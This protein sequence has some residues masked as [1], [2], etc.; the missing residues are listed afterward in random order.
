MKLFESAI[1]AM[2]DGGVDFIV[3]G[4]LAANLL[5]SR[6][7]TYDID[8][9]FSRSRANLQRLSAALA[10]LH[11]RLR[12]LPPGLPFVWDEKSLRRSKRVQSK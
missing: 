12:G 9:C 4:G 7:V 6:R 5:G 10:P 3:I 8:F 1:Q 11:P 2:V